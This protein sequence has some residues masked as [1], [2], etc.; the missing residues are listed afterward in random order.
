MFNASTNRTLTPRAFLAHA[1]TKLCVDVVPKLVSAVLAKGVEREEPWL[2]LHV[3]AANG[4]LE[5][6][7]G[8]VEGKVTLWLGDAQR[9]RLFPLGY[10]P[11]DAEPL[12]IGRKVWRSDAEVWVN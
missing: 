5:M 1:S 12:L 2:Q 10:A 6:L 3:Q 4:K 8:D 11:A 9:K 7:S